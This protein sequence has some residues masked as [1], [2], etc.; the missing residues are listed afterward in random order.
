MAASL[1]AG[2]QTQS[3]PLIAPSVSVVV[4]RHQTAERRVDGV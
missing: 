4:P 2:I 1:A 3:F